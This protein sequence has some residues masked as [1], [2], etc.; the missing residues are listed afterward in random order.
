M[1]VRVKICGVTRVEDALEAARCGAS[2]IGMV[3]APA[4]P[5]VVTIER[6]CD[7]SAAVA[8]AGV[9][10]VGVFV[11]QSPAF[12]ADVAR[13]AHLDAVQLHGHESAAEYRFGLPIVKAFGVGSAWHIGMLSDLPP[14]VLP[15]LDATDGRRSG[16]MGLVIDWTLAAT[17]ASVRRIVLAGGLTPDNVEV[18]ITTASPFAVDVS[19][20]VEASPGVKDAHRLRGFIEAVEAAAGPVPRRLFE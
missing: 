9:T 13:R 11:D 1:A 19:S 10:R 16:G 7:I 15:L 2:A 4:S 14:D 17:A 5:R 8:G 20:G 3:F 6:A 12:V 18:A